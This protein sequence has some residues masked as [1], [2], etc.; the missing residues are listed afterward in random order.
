[1][2]R[3]AHQPL[4]YP[5]RIPVVTIDEIEARLRAGSPDGPPKHVVIGNRGNSIT[6]TIAFWV[7]GL[8]GAYFLGR[9]IG[10]AF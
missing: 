6:A 7:V 1:M 2:T 5:E 4:D 8:T 3:P 10:S 9:L